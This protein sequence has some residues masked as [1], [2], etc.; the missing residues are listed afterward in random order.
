MS[1]GSMTVCR[2]WCK[3]NWR[4]WRMAAE[5]PAKLCAQIGHAGPKAAVQVPW[6]DDE[7]PLAKLVEARY[8]SRETLLRESDVL[9]LHAPLNHDSRHAIDAAA[10]GASLLLPTSAWHTNYVAV[11]AYD[12]EFARVWNAVSE[13]VYSIEGMRHYESLQRNIKLQNETLGKAVNE[14]GR[15]R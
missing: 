2:S 13:L 10:T 5:T 15:V 6:E 14:V 8:V 7:A 11:S 4:R 12:T 1:G 9:T 3:S